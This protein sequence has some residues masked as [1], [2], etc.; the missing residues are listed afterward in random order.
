MVNMEFESKSEI[1]INWRLTTFPKDARA[2]LQ[3]RAAARKYQEEHNLSGSVADLVAEQAVIESSVIYQR[4]QRDVNQPITFS[5]PT[6]LLKVLAR[7][8]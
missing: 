5:L 7:L 4:A 2:V 8:P 6:G 1:P 3:I